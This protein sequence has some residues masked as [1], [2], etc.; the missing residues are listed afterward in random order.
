MQG[1]PLGGALAPKVWVDAITSISDWNWTSLIVGC[2]GILFLFIMKKANTAFLP[3]VPLPNQL[4]LVVLATAI[5]YSFSLH[6]SPYYM[7]ILGEI[8]SGLPRPKLPTF[9]VGE[10]ETFSNLF[11][12]ALLQSLIAAFVFYIITV[13]IGKTFS[14]R[15]SGCY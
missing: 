13:S 4:F 9:N 5:T 15:V 8:Q 3:R 11:G 2:T 12:K 1:I 14:M 7:S 6:E 10:D